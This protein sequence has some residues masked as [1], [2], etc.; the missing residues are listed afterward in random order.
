MGPISS[1]LGEIYQFEVKAEPMCAPGE[2]DGVVLAGVPP[3]DGRARQ[4]ANGTL[5]YPHGAANDPRL[6]RQLSAPFGAGDRRGEL[7]RRAAQDLPGDPRCPDSVDLLRAVGGRRA[8]RPSEAS[9]RNGGRRLHRP[10]AA[11]S[12][13]IRGEATRRGRWRISATVV[14][15]HDAERH[16]GLPSRDVGRG[17]ARAHDPPGRGDPRR[18]RAK[19]SSAS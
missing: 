12:T 7:L 8:S 4:R 3:D 6:V 18:P 19:R 14:L 5:P 13:S 16:A 15:A 11:S 10:P 1:G 9:N 17:R 2:P